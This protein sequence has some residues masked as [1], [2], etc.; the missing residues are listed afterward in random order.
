MDEAEEMG[1]WE[2]KFL[3]KYTLKIVTKLYFFSLKASKLS[4]SWE[5][6]G[7]EENFRPRAHSVEH[8]SRAKIKSVKQTVVIIVGYIFCSTPAVGLQLWAVWKEKKD[9]LGNFYTIICNSNINPFQKHWFI[10][11][12]EKKYWQQN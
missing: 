3:W 6:V 7:E 12:P 11:M 1:L 9:N 10:S 2:G 8:I 4:S 5:D